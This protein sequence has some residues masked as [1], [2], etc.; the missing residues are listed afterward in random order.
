[1]VRGHL[2]YLTAKDLEARNTEQALRLSMKIWGLS[3]LKGVVLPFTTLK[4][5]LT[6]QHLMVL[7]S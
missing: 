7:K 3:V 5:T 2:L 1:M 6:Y 4:K